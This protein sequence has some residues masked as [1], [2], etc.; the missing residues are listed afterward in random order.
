MCSSF[1]AFVAFSDGKPDSTFPENALA[2]AQ[3]ASNLAFTGD[4]RGYE[5]SLPP[6]SATARRIHM[7]LHMT[8][9]GRR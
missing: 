9:Q 8:R 5:L 4:N 1:L 7:T 6:R 2:K 3:P